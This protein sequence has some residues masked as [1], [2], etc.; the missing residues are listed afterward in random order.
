MKGKETGGG[1]YKR[2]VVC[3]VTS[4]QFFLVSHQ[5]LY[6]HIMQAGGYYHY[7]FMHSRQIFFMTN[8]LPGGSVHPYNCAIVEALV[9]AVQ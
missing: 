2:Q 6:L 1:R 5:V 3:V 9:D 8:M 4:A 7:I